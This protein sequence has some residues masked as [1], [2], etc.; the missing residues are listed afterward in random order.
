MGK[1]AQDLLGAFQGVGGLGTQSCL[2]LL[3]DLLDG[4]IGVQGLEDLVSDHVPQPLTLLLDT[5][6]LQGAVR[7]EVRTMVDDGLPD[8]VEPLLGVR[9]A[10]QHRNTP[11][12]GIG[13]DELHG[14]GQVTSGDTRV[15]GIVAIGLVD[16]NDVRQF[17][18]ALLDALQLVAGTRDGEH[19]EGVDHACHGDLGLSDTDGLDEHHVVTSCLHD[20]HGLAC[21]PGDATQVT[22]GG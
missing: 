6:D 10:G 4:G 22:A 19:E 12:V 7:L 8:V 2:D 15:A 16:R 13:G 18:D 14:D 5:A 11:L 21:G 3:C 17:Q 1:G 20:D 9:G